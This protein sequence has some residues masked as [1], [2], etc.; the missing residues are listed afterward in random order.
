MQEDSSKGKIKGSVFWQYLYAGG[1]VFFVMFVIFLYLLSQAIGSGIDYFVSYWVNVE[2]FQNHTEID[3]VASVTDNSIFNFLHNTDEY[4]YFFGV[5]VILLFVVALIRSMLFYKLAM[6]SSQKLHD[7][8][9]TN[10]L[11]APMRF[12]DTNPSGRILNRFSKDMGAVDELLP[13]VILDAAQVR[14][15]FKPSAIM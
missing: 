10:I 11:K 8:M 3:G 9:F 1:N 6:N 13:K 12:F 4:L 7:V 15:N 14:H 5:L 2:E